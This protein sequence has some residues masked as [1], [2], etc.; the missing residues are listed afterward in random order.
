MGALDVYLD[1]SGYTGPDLL[2]VD[3]P[4]YTLGSVALSEEVAAELKA[5]CFPGVKAQE[6]HHTALAKRPRGR[7]QVLSLIHELAGIP[8]AATIVVAHKPYVLLGL[9]VDFWVEPAMR[10]DGLNLYEQ[11]ANIGLVNVAWMVL[12]A[13]LGDDR[14]EFLR[15]FQVMVRDRTRFAEESFWTTVHD[16]CQRHPEFDQT[17][18]LFETA[19]MRLGAKHLS[20]LPADLLDLGEYGLLETV[21][22][23]RKTTT[24]PLRL[25]HDQNT[26]LQRNRK[27]WDAWLSKDVPP[28]VVGQDRRVIRF[29]LNGTIEMADSRAAVPL[30]LADLIAG[31]TA[32]M[33]NPIAGRVARDPD[34]V[35]ALRDSPL[36]ERFV[37]GGVWPSDK[38]TPED[39]GTEGPV[40]GDSADYLA[41]LVRESRREE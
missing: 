32:A 30:Q 1:E 7:R 10:L 12:G 33:L 36:S 6:L 5:K 41:S 15:R 26:S 16:L 37:I 29:P 8:N 21:T 19:N 2:N 23:W 27:Q 28:A 14:R 13:I 24:E 20:R 22:H 25:I 9:L 11:G 18:G 40:Y 39:L 35:D 17:I 38:V 3:Q 34:Y 4:V 31:A